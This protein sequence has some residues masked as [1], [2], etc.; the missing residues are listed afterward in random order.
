MNGALERTGRRTREAIA[1]YVQVAAVLGA[2]GV[3][4]FRRSNWSGPVR[5]VLGR[6]ILFTG[7]DALRFVSFVAIVV[8]LSVVVQTQ[9]WLLRVGQSALVGPLLVAVVMREAGPLL[10][11]FIVIGRSGTAM[12]AEL[13]QMRVSGEVEVLDSQGVDPFLYLVMPRVAGAAVSTF[14]LT[15]VFLV[16]ALAGGF[17]LGTL[18]GMRMGLPSVFVR[19]VFGA[20]RPADVVS[21]LLKTL[22]PGAVTAAI[23]SSEG[24]RVGR[25]TTEIPIAAMRGV[26]R[27]VI[28]LFVVSGTVSVLGYL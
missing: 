16:L 7:I 20:I 10:V 26:T 19:S 11:N 17:F 4:A 9:V 8:G 3:Q 1:A 5:S 2:V 14:C 27:S 23:C 6:Q 12:A 22:I 24:L 28:A 15:V 13:A 21:M 18:L 25:A